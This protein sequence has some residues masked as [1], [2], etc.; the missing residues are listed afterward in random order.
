[1]RAGRKIGTLAGGG[2]LG[3]QSLLGFEPFHGRAAGD[4]GVDAAPDGL[5]GA[6]GVQRANGGAVGT[7]GGAAGSGRGG[8]A[9]ANAPSASSV[10][11]AKLSRTD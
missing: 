9:G 7:A 8:T 4:A 1:M 5:G 10:L 6:P 2:L 3:C 11:L